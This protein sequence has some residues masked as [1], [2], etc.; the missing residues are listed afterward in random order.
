VEHGSYATLKQKL[1]ILAEYLGRF[2]SDLESNVDWV[3]HQWY[4]ESS[5]FEVAFSTGWR[6]QPRSPLDGL[7]FCGYTTDV[8]GTSFAREATSAMEVADMF[9]AH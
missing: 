3:E 8:N 1:A 4:P 2:Y 9:L 6:P 5:W 7:L